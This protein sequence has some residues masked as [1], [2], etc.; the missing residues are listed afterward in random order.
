[1]PTPTNRALY[2]RVVQAAKRRF[3]AWPSAYAS[4]WVVQEY[5]RRGGR[6]RGGRKRAGRKRSGRR[7][8]GLGRWFR[9]KWVDVCEWP[10]RV[11]CGR[12]RRGVR[13]YPYCRPTRRVSKRTPRL[14]QD[15]T[16][17][18]RRSRC[19]RKKSRPRKKV[20]R[21]GAA[22]LQVV[23][24]S[25]ESLR[26]VRAMIPYYQSRGIAAKLSPGSAFRMTLR[27]ADGEPLRT[28]HEPPTM[29]EAEAREACEITRPHCFADETH[30]TC[31]LL[32]PKARAYADRSGNPIGRASEDEFAR[33]RKGK[34]PGPTDLTSW[35]TC[36][37]SAV[38][39]HYAERFRD[40]TRV[41][42][43]RNRATGHVRALGD[44]DDEA[45]LAG[46]RRHRTPGVPP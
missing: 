2:R 3:K 45:T 22:T 7:S 21:G 34:R 17:A 42:F 11:P 43:V 36:A 4:G 30:Q 5:K 28:W 33:A 10:R 1:M 19:R 39:T 13:S 15:L 24:D 31:C 29:T 14:A 46:A 32:G 6:Y 35:C 37:G 16:A 41:K 25:A 26:R 20:F 40:G 27:G 38:C 12:G 44:G 23:Y 9:E 18:E 8:S